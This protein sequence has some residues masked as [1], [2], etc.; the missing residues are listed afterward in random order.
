MVLPGFG[1][2]STESRKLT[3]E[4][5]FIILARILVTGKFKLKAGVD[6]VL[7]FTW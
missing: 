3:E 5:R 2:R 4:V 6:E 1:K 7:D